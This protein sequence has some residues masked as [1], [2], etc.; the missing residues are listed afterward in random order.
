MIEVAVTEGVAKEDE[1]VLS[2]HIEKIGN[3]SGDISKYKSMKLG[4]KKTSLKKKKS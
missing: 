3:S 1:M 4:K 2:P